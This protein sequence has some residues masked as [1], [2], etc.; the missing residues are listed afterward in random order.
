V[1]TKTGTNINEAISLLERG[2]IVAIPTE[3]VYGLAGNGTDE[4]AIQKIYKAK[5]RPLSNPLILHFSNLENL[6]NYVKKLPEHA[7]ILAE[8]FWPGPLTLLLDK[9]DAIPD[10]VN[11]GNRRVAVRIPKHE[12]TLKLLSKIDFPLAAPSANLYGRIS[13]TK[14]EHVLNQLNQI[15]PYVL[16]GG[17]CNNG[18]ESTI[19]GFDENSPMIYRLGAITVEQIESCLGQKVNIHNHII[20]NSGPDASGMVKFHYA[21]RTPMYNI[22]QISTKEDTSNFGYIGFDTLNFLIPAENQFLLSE[23]G[24][25]RIASKNLYHAMHHMDQKHFEK[26]FICDFPNEELGRSMNDRIKKAI[27]KF[28]A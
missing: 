16:N 10:L 22:E 15:I 12:M 28:N 2:E 11:S 6:S 8:Q 14:V 13:P 21:P 26:I 9:S 5:K 3:T 27:A 7:K 1:K 18:I 17:D 4:K 19:V 25:L 23:D 24:D 20:Q